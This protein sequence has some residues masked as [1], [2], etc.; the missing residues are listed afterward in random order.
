MVRWNLFVWLVDQATL[1]ST[2]DDVNT[3]ED[4]YCLFKEHEVRND[5]SFTIIVIN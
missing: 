2:E 1:P 5:C 3:I 4:I